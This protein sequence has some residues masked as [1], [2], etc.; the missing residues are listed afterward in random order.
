MGAAM[1]L[2]L[3]ESRAKEYDWEFPIVKI[4]VV[5]VNFTTLEVA[6]FLKKNFDK[7]GKNL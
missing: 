2:D 4:N 6:K 3:L 1:V 7:H 5:R